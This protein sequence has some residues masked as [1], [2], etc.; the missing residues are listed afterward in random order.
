MVILQN[1]EDDSL[2]NPGKFSIIMIPQL[3][4]SFVNQQ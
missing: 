2:V 1:V 3:L 4:M